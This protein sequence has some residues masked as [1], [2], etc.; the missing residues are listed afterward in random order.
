MVFAVESHIEEEVWEEVSRFINGKEQ[1]A[2]AF[3]SGAYSMLFG[4]FLQSGILIF[5]ECQ[6]RSIYF[7]RL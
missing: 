6:Y 1:P 7:F 3:L 4:V 5:T 2:P